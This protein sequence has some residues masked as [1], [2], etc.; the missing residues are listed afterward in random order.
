MN[1]DGQKSDDKNNGF[2]VQSDITTTVL[3]A[4]MKISGDP[5]PQ[6]CMNRIVGL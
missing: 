5:L 6:F 3:T 2:A 1:I 4:A